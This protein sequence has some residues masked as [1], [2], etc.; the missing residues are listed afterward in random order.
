VPDSRMRAE[1]TRIREAARD[2]RQDFK[3]EE[4]E[5]NWELVE[6]K[7]LRP[8]VQLRTQIADELLRR[9]AQDQRVPVD[10]DPVPPQYEEAVRKY[11]ELLGTGQ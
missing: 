11:Y 6:L 1:A 9:S 10:R 3:R 4:K 8:L 7:V 5:P 2:F